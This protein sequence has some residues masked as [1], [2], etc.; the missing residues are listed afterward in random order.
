MTEPSVHILFETSQEKRKVLG[1]IVD[2]LGTNLSSVLN[3]A[4]DNYIELYEWQLAHIARGVEQAK[5]RDFASN[6]EVKN[7]FEKYGLGS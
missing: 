5:E 6:K 7:V 1:K 2:S 4:V 3:D